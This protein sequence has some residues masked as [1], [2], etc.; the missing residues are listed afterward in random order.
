[1]SKA[2]RSV[3]VFGVYLIVAGLL[4]LLIPNV[5]LGMFGLPGTED[6]WV[7]VVGVIVIRLG[8]LYVSSAR[9]ELVAF[10]RATLTS[11]GIYIVLVVGLIIAGVLPPVLVLFPIV[12]L[13]GAVWTA[14]ALRGSTGTAGQRVS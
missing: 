4:F 8:Y 12:D 14:M 11:R 6:P 10:F 9:N 5:A 3:F 7:R 1:M 13:L 2:A